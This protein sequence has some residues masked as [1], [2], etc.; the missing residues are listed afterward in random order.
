MTTTPNFPAVIVGSG[1]A[2]TRESKIVLFL[3]LDGSATGPFRWTIPLRLIVQGDTFPDQSTLPVDK[4][5][6]F[7]PILGYSNIAQPVVYVAENIIINMRALKTL[8]P[9]ISDAEV[10]SLSYRGPRFVKGWLSE[11]IIDGYLHKLCRI[12]NDVSFVPC[13]FM[14]C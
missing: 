11:D 12:R 4:S 8:D 7:T 6:S 1:D 9:Y 5:K 3:P 10:S 14:H 2:Y 13:L